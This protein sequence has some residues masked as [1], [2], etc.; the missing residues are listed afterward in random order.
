MPSI[1]LLPWREAER[2][3]RQREFLA[4]MAASFVA[5]L[6]V[7]GL[8][9]FVY[10]GM[11]DTQNSRNA[12]LTAEIRELDKSIEE[13]EGLERQK[14]RLLARMEIIERLQK[15][16]PEIVH[17]FDEVAR[18]LPEGVYLTGMRQ[19]G[20][21]VEVTGMAQSSTRVSALMRQIESSD[22]L[23][24]PGVTRVRTTDAGPAREAEFVVTLKQ[25]SKSSDE[26][27]AG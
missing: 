8:V 1:N 11:I 18:R 14:E 5:A 21:D 23:T 4:A 24:D 22:W 20:A 13:I 2:Q 17:L 3:K 9:V 19:A 7:I 10:D 25:V 12:R 15:S 26:E 27:D 16:R 6:L